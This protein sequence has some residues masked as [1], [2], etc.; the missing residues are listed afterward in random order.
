MTPTALFQLMKH[1][2]WG[3]ATALAYGSATSGAV[4]AIG[5]RE[6][7]Q[8]YLQAYFVSFNCLIS[9]GLILGT[10]IFVYLSQ[11]SVPAFIENAFD[12]KSLQGTLFHDEKLK[13]LSTR[14]SIIFASYFIV[15]GFLI[16]YFCKFPLRGVSEYFMI[17]FGCLEYALG[18][19]V[20]RKLF[21]IARMLHSIL[22]I[23]MT[24][25]IFKNDDLGYVINYVNV[26]STLTIIFV[27][28]HVTS[29][30]RGPFEYSSILNES[31]SVALMLPA[32]IATPVLIIFNFYP[33][34][35]LRALYSRSIAD[36]VN[37]LTEKLNAKNLSDF[38][39]LSYIIEYHKLSKDELRNRLR[40][41]LSD[42]PIAIT[43]VI[44][45]VGLLVKH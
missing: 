20:G 35:A 33:R 44:M 39:K 16:F 27:Y 1:L 11:Q 30:Y 4:W 9:G 41:S 45:I 15:A 37:S 8:K 19:Y 18:V 22:N 38:E 31:L 2:F 26:L 3:F 32:V 10:A 34:T 5:S 23:K 6:A 42:L 25:N 17:F 21:Y 40:L 28:I 14:R 24:R 29:Y 7:F 12:E 13:Y 36:E 43:I